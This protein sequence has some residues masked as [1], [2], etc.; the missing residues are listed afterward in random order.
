M[1]VLVTARCVLIESSCSEQMVFFLSVCSP[2]SWST[3]S[4]SWESNWRRCL[5]PWVGKMC[6][7]FFFFTLLFPCCHALRVCSLCHLDSS[8]SIM[9]Q[10]WPVRTCL[11][12]LGRRVSVSLLQLCEEA[13]DILKDL[14]VKLNNVMDDLSRIFSV[15]YRKTKTK[16]KNVLLGVVPSRLH[17]LHLLLF[18]KLPASH[19]GEREADG[20]H[21]GS[22]EGHRQRGERQ[23]RRPGRR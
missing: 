13:S 10:S 23:Q 11:S 7:G 2:A 8:K 5:K 3:T 22:G 14:Q 19:R 15:R 20:R 1:K 16:K 4:S 17:C 12:W 9:S 6:V 18:P 21:P